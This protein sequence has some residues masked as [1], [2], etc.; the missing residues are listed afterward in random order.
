MVVQ[1]MV[2]SPWTA[3]TLPEKTARPSLSNTSS[4]SASILIGSLLAPKLPKPTA[5]SLPPTWA[6]AAGPETER[7][8]APASATCLKLIMDGHL[9]VAPQE[10]QGS[11]RQELEQ[12]GC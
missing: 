5:R 10:P 11:R 2:L 7:R 4:L 12:G 6:H 3:T 9:S 8:T 1:F